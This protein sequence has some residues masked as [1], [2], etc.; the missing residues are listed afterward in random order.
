MGQVLAVQ[1]LLSLPCLHDQAAKMFDSSKKV[2]S[3]IDSENQASSPVARPAL[4]AQ[5]Q[6]TV[7]TRYIRPTHTYRAQS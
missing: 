7:A 3:R 5:R 1:E 2:C 6:F 4:A